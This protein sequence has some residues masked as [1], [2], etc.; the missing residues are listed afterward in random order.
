[1][2]DSIQSDRFIEFTDAQLSKMENLFCTLTDLVDVKGENMNVVDDIMEEDIEEEE[3]ERAM[4]GEIDIEK[5][6]DDDEGMGRMEGGREREEG[7]EGGGEF[8]PNAVAKTETDTPNQP[9]TSTPAG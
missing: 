9:S 6:G 1:M 2:Y 8:T 5:C 4:S 3:G 7:G